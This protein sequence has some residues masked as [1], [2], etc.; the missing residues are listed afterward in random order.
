MRTVP[1]VIALLALLVLYAPVGRDLVAVWR[2]VPYYSYGMLVPLF[3]LYLGWDA[4]HR[5][6][7]AP[8]PRWP[9]GLV[10]AIAGLGVLAVG[11]RLESL[12]LTVL[13]FPVVLAGAG[14]FVAGPRGFR[15][16]AFPVAF[17]AL[18]APLPEPA[19]AALSLPL[20]HLAAA[21]TDGVL[22]A[23]GIPAYREGLFIQLTTV[24]LHI[25][26]ACNGLRFLL[27]MVVIGVAFAWAIA[28]P[29]LHRLAVVP[30][31]VAVAIAANLVRVTGT[32]LLA[33]AWGPEAAGGFFHLAY[34]KVV[35][36]AML[37]SFVAGVLLLRRRAG[38]DP[39]HA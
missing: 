6:P 23:L 34:G 7:L 39:H 2:A 13:S 21:V 10:V 38:E 25:S 8:R 18:A 30:L 9:G 33:H 32:A 20:Q 17:L 31:A 11:V 14:L 12:T 4:R 36:A 22:S 27:A 1:T 15:P 26:E 24:R 3:S 29:P 19:L 16:F 5:W 37:V 28:A 35:Y